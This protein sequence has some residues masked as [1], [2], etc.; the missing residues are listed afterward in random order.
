[1][2]IRFYQEGVGK[3]RLKI[4]W[5]KEIL[6]QLVSEH[7]CKIGSLNYIFCDDSYLLEMNVK[8][9]DH[10]DF[11]DV[12]TF[13][14]CDQNIVSGDIFISVERVEENAKVFGEGLIRELVRVIFHGCLHLLKYGDK[15]EE[16]I[17]VMRKMESKLIAQY[18]GE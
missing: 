11:T 1:M 13:D 14:Y 6:V 4:I 9:L 10:H 18:F 5:L 17:G 2:A 16:E 12:I 3:Q 8:F 7:N 15:A